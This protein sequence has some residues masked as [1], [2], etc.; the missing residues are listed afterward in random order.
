MTG[1]LAPSLHAVRL[2]ALEQR[3]QYAR[4]RGMD[5]LEYWQNVPQWPKGRL[6]E[7]LQP[8]PNSA[9]EYP[10]SRG[11]ASLVEAIR[12]REIRRQCVDIDREG[13][14]VTNGALHALSLIFAH[15]A[16]R[17]SWSLCEAPVF[18][19]VASR[20]ADAGLGVRFFR[21]T[22]TGLAD[23]YGEY[24]LQ[25][26]VDDVSLIYIA[27]PNNPFGTTIDARHFPALVEWLDKFGCPLVVDMVYDDFSCFTHSDGLVPLLSRLPWDRL[28][29]VN[30]VSKNFGVPGLRIGWVI[31]SPTNVAALNRRLEDDC[32]AVSAP[33]QLYARDLMVAGNAELQAVVTEGERFMRSWATQNPDLPV[34]RYKGSVQSLAPAPTTSVTKFADRLLVDYGLLV[35]TSENYAGVRSDEEFIRLPFGYPTPFLDTVLSILRGAFVHLQEGSG[36]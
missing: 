14:L 32:I 23:G 34:R 2:S 29:L 27:M 5:L 8:I 31:S 13:I 16:T 9:H 1:V 6:A 4:A 15:H 25:P 26:G 7:T 10:P 21:P 33:A 17:H 11:L 36:S 3:L 20:L 22:P 35:A 18:R 28:Y 19:G 24:P 30:S 12:E